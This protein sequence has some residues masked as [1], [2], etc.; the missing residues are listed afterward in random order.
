[1]GCEDNFTT[2]DRHGIIKDKTIFDGGHEG[3]GVYIQHPNGDRYPYPDIIEREY[4][5]RNPMFDYMKC[6]AWRITW[7]DY[8]GSA[9]IDKI[10]TVWGTNGGLNSFHYL[11]NV[12]AQATYNTKISLFY[13]ETLISSHILWDELDYTFNALDNM[14]SVRFVKHDLTLDK[15]KDWVTERPQLFEEYYPGV[16]VN[17]IEYEEGDFF[18]YYLTDQLLYGGVRIVSM[19]PR[20]I[21][22]YLVVPNI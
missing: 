1:V 3:P 8:A 10:P 5:P 22:V 7:P 11:N 13:K 12:G 20:I 17:E 15:I 16:G 9:D 21:E 14:E 4:I 2:S 18:I 19:S 6:L